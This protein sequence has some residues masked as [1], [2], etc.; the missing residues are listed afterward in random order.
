MKKVGVIGLGNMGSGIAKNLCKANFET[1]GFDLSS[2]RII[3]FQ[4]YGGIATSKIQDIATICDTVF[5]MV[6]NK[7]QVHVIVDELIQVMQPHQTIIIT[8][9][10]EPSE[11]V[12]VAEKIQ[13][14]NIKIIDSPVS[15]GLNGAKDGTLTLMLAAKLEVIEENRKVLEAI[16]STIHCVGEKAG[17]GQ[18][19]K[20]AL[21]I[22]IGV[23]YAG[24]FEAMTLGAKAG[25]S[26][27]VMFDVFTTSAVNS[28]ILVNCMKLIN[29]RIF[30]KS[31]SHIDTMH[32]D[33][34]ISTQLA[35]ELQVP[36]FTANAA[37]QLFESARAMFPQGDNW[38]I[39]KFLE[40]ITK[41][42]VKW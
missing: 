38:I 34:G 36:V 4:L 40:Q 24:I 12:L 41:S 1:Y 2:D 39:V 13:S 29:D 10:I 22:L 15:G 37:F 31:G 11:I 23:S 20:A 27:Q 8:A 17:L 28:P 5:I 21:Q 19:V 32:K 7:K 6:M 9:T 26:G 16:S 42:E 35:R 25:V 14:K 33:L 3:E 30:E 18:T